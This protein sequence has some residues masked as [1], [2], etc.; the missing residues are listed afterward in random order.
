MRIYEARE[1]TGLTQR[2]LSERTGFER[3]RISYWESGTDCI[4]LEKLIKLAHVLG[5]SVGWLVGE[6]R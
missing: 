2:E 4:P 1:K 5:V 6:V 3:S